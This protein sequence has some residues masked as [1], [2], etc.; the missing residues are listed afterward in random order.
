MTKTD[1]LKIVIGTRA[2]QLARAQTEE[3]AAR[4]REEGA[5]AIIKTIRT[6]GD[7]RSGP[8]AMGIGVFV[9]EI[10]RALLDGEVDLAVH[11]LKDLPTGHREGLVVAAVPVR[12]DAS[13]ALV[14]RAGVGLAELPAG[15]RIA[16]SSPRRVAQLRAY[17]PDLVFEP[18]RGNLDTR[19]RKLSRGDFDALVIANAGLIRMG[20]ADRATERL[21]FEICLP[22]PAQG[23]LALQVR[24]TDDRLIAFLSPFDHPPSRLAV[25]AERA[26]LARL[27]AGCSLPVGALAVVEGHT[28]LLRGAV[29]DPEGRFVIRRQKEGP[30]EESEA[31]GQRLADEILA[32]GADR[33]LGG[34]KW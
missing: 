29:A 1:R 30:A 8:L 3:V 26:F 28:L 27:G 14:S 33:I 21:P 11:S 10:E 32:E 24:E 2:S 15:S 34:C 5:D 18:V 23:A 31:L 20:L 22:A 9:R 19:L 4:L 16:T 12:A 25:T 17:R 13:D 6:T 7:M